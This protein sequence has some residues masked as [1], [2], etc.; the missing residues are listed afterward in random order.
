MGAQT[1]ADQGVKM[2]PVGFIPWRTPD[3]P[4]AADRAK[5]FC[6][7]RGLTA[8]DVKLR[9]VDGEVIVEVIKECKCKVGARKQT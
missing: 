8:N 2:M 7:T 9:R 4:D 1:G 6:R 3:A 5:E